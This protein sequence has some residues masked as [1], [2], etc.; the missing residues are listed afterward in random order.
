MTTESQI[1]A[2][3]VGN[4]KGIKED[5]SHCIEH[6]SDGGRGSFGITRQC[7]FKRGKGLDG[8]YCGVHAKRYPVT[9]VN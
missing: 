4:S 9:E 5:L 1:Y 2:Q 6:V 7:R 8:L 3:W